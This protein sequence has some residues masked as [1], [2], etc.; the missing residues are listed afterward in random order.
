[1]D[2]YNELRKSLGMASADKDD[3]GEVVAFVV[4]FELL[5]KTVADECGSLPADERDTFMMTFAAYLKWLVMLI[6]EARFPEGTW[7][8]IS[9]V[10]ERELARQPWHRSQTM[11]SI[12]NMMVE[13]PPLEAKG[14]NFRVLL[15]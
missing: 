13:L 10:L 5:A 7:Q 3:L 15:P 9:P 6:V 11:G 14:L 4:V 2:E 8:I 1:M 12:Y